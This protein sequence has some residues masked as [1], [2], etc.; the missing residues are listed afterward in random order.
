MQKKMCGEQMETLGGKVGLLAYH[1]ATQKKNNR[2][3]FAFRR[4]HDV[5]IML[6]CNDVIKNIFQ[7]HVLLYAHY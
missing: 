3:P 4:L 6:L 2:K 1:L 7:F 5:A